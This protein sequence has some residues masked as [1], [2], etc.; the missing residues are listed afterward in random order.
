MSLNIRGLNT[1]Q[2]PGKSRQIQ[3][4]YLSSFPPMTMMTFLILMATLGIVEV[5]ERLRVWQREA[6]LL[7]LQGLTGQNIGRF[8]TA[9]GVLRM[10]SVTGHRLIELGKR[11]GKR[12]A[13][14]LQLLSLQCIPFI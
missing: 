12:S 1:E 14:F 2:S 11:N 9:S 3:F 10:Q 7:G 5:W 8:G 13:W 6:S 4:S